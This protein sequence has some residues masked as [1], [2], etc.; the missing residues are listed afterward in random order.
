VFK[1]TKVQ[2]TNPVTYLLKD[3]CGKP[4]AVGFYEYE[5][6]RVANPVVYL[7]EK[8]LRKRR[9]EVYVK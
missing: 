7:V 3:S 6:R 2:K 1:I 8:V 5:L 9:N 4:V